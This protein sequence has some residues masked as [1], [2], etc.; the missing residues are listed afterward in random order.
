MLN[1]KLTPVARRHFHRADPALR[2]R[3]LSRL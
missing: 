2:S 3:R 1:E